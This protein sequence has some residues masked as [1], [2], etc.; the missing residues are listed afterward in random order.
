MLRN[1]RDFFSFFYPAFQRAKNEDEACDWRGD[2]HLAMLE[3]RIVVLRPPLEK[4]ISQSSK[5]LSS[6]M[7][8]SRRVSAS[9]GNLPELEIDSCCQKSTS[10]S[11]SAKSLK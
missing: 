11:G 3:S 9:T 6:P 7:L 5:D 10:D 4:E 1:F 8:S 2:L